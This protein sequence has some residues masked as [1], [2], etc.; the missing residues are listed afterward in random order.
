MILVIDVLCYRYLAP[1]KDRQGKREW[2]ASPAENTNC[3]GKSCVPCWTTSPW[4]SRWWGQSWPPGWWWAAGQTGRGSASSSHRCRSCKRGQAPAWAGCRPGWWWHTAPAP[5]AAWSRHTKTGTRA[6]EIHV[7]KKNTYRRYSS[8][9]FSKIGHG[10]P[11]NQGE[12]NRDQRKPAMES[13]IIRILT[14]Y[15]VRTVLIKTLLYFN[16]STKSAI[17]VNNINK[18]SMA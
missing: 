15:W 9:L 16:M 1:K 11:Q 2:K 13:N 14:W 8:I 5:S 6:M 17:V 4:G 18:I 3:Q 12:F 7:K 10:M